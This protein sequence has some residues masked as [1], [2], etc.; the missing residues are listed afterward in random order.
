[1]E[2]ILKSMG[3]EDKIPLFKQSNITLET[4]EKCQMSDDS[5]E[6]IKSEAGLSTG[7][8]IILYQKVTEHKKFRDSRLMANPSKSLYPVSNPLTHTT[9]FGRNKRLSALVQPQP[10]QII[11]KPYTLE[12]PIDLISRDLN[13]S[14]K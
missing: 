11:K 6:M 10:K 14:N 7:Q 3:L 8:L 4:I 5:L 1:M 13:S 2:S 9:T 12:N